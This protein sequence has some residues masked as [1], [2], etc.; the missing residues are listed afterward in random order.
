MSAR[1]P[2][3]CYEKLKG[4]KYRL[5]RDYYIFIP[6]LMNYS[7]STEYIKV[8]P[9]GLMLITANYAWDGA[10]GPT[11]DTKNSMRGSLV[12][13]VLYQLIRLGLLPESFKETADEYL[14]K[15][16]KVDGMSSF[17]AGYWEK[18]VRW[19]GG[20]SI[21]RRPEE[22]KLYFAPYEPEEVL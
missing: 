1:P 3:I 8:R 22:G 6:E 20:L 10:S 5:K 11:L 14:E 7:I 21:W 2:F 12:H 19:F 18:A 15:I 9:N 17:R 4:Y 13:D 16:C